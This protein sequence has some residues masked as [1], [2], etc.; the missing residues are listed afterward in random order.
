MVNQEN[1]RLLFINHLFIVRFEKDERG[2]SKKKCPYSG[3]S[4]AN[5][6]ELLTDKNRNDDKGQGQK[7]A[8]NE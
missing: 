8:D 6:S 1:V 4:E 3:S 7:H 5:P 2:R